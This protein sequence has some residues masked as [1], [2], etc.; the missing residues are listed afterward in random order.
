MALR[1]APVDNYGINRHY[2]LVLSSSNLYSS[3]ATVE[4]L[5]R[6]HG[7]LLLFLF[8]FIVPRRSI[9]GGIPAPFDRRSPSQPPQELAAVYCIGKDFI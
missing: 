1:T 4:L 2:K 9:D 6:F 7:E 3:G 8:L 5:M